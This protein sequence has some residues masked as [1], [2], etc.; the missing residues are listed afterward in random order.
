MADGELDLSSGFTNYSTFGLNLADGSPDTTDVA[1]LGEYSAHHGA[2]GADLLDP[3]L[4]GVALPESVIRTYIGDPHDPQVEEAVKA[5]RYQVEVQLP[6]GSTGTAPLIDIGPGASTGRGIDISYGFAK[7]LNLSDDSGA[8]HY[9]LFE[10]PNAEVVSQDATS[11]DERLNGKEPEVEEKH[12]NVSPISAM[13]ASD[14]GLAGYSDDQLNERISQ[15]YPRVPRSQVDQFSNLPNGFELLKRAKSLYDTPLARAKDQDPVL[16]A[17]SDKDALAALY[18][19]FGDKNKEGLAEFSARMNP[20]DPNAT[21]KTNAFSM[22]WDTVRKDTAEL[23]R[24]LGPQSQIAGLSTWRG[25]RELA[26][27]GG[28]N[29]VNQALDQV[30]GQQSP[31]DRGKLITQY[32]NSDP[33]E[34]KKLFAQAVASNAGALA[35]KR[36]DTAVAFNQL[37]TGLLGMKDKQ[38]NQEAVD[39]MT[40]AIGK[41][42]TDNPGTLPENQEKVVKL[43][44]QAPAQAA[45]SLFPGFREMGLYSQLYDSNLQEI[46]AANPKMDPKEIDRRAR[47]AADAQF[48]A[49]EALAFMLKNG[50]G[51]ITASITNKVLK[52]GAD[53]LLA[54][55][56]GGSVFATNQAIQN[57]AAN[58]NLQ[59]GVGE[60]FF[61]GSI[62]GGAASASIRVPELGG[63]LGVKM[64]QDYMAKSDAGKVVAGYM[65]SVSGAQ[66]ADINKF[67]KGDKDNAIDQKTQARAKDV[68]LSSIEKLGDKVPKPVAEA[69][70]KARDSHGDE[71][72]NHVETAFSLLS[73][74]QKKAVHQDVVDSLKGLSDKGGNV[75]DSYLYPNFEA[76]E[77][78]ARIE[79]SRQ[80]QKAAERGVLTG[81]GATAAQGELGAPLS[82]AEQKIEERRIL[83]GKKYRTFETGEP[84]PQRQEEQRILTGKPTLGGETLEREV[85]SARPEQLDRLRSLYN[86]VIMRS[87]DCD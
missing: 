32:Q 62:V 45:L 78:T 86:E 67:L 5:G 1:S 42:D 34:Q 87:I 46:R 43:L 22:A 41:I 10:N 65:D 68:I 37:Q 71:S 64:V 2:W 75:S 55:G 72:A 26:V 15:F 16:G 20:Q 44:A 4:R 23:F 83:T 61:H 33:A 69:I 3:S 18:N 25:A 28:E 58:K 12:Q 35:Q 14:P 56:A 82:K 30:Y 52:A 50:G 73:S 13:R 51:A 66:S 63:R 81:Q 77:V 40:K 48:P 17:M 7:E 19:R 36:V 60:A 70:Q 80:G 6:D 59:D 24:Q 47:L 29:Q 84:S 76:P 53:V 85:S 49:Q 79:R 39:W 74:A 8:L 31:E 38:A 21:A 11:V 57:V 27:T 9:R 54:S